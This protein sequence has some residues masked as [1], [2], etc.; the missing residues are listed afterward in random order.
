MAWSDLV[1]KQIAISQEGWF[2]HRRARALR[3]SGMMFK[4]IAALLGVST[5][6]ARQLVIKPISEVS[7]VEKYLADATPLPKGKRRR[8]LLARKLRRAS[9]GKN[10]LTVKHNENNNLILEVKP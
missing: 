10:W 6:R 9:S 8:Y 2:R 3:D 7:P 5:P 1:P 4:E